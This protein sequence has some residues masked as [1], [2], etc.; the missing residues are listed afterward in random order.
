[1]SWRAL[2]S[3]DPELARLGRERLESV[4]MGVLGTIRA[5]GTPRVS[6]VGVWF[7]EGELVVGVMPRSGK[8]ADLRRDPRCALQSVVTDPEAGAPEL[9]LYGRLVPSK[10]EAGWWEGS[11]ES[12]DVYAMDLDEAVYIE[13]DLAQSR[14][15]VRRWT[16][17]QSAHRI[18]K[19][20]P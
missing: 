2:E 4:G 6:P 13:W 10:L 9:K 7:V 16:P 12:A 17:G 8:A 19:T 5:D 1:V 15:D 14:M 18:V 11:P 3:K 20:Y